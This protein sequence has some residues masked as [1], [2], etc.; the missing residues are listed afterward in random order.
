[1]LQLPARLP[2]GTGH[3][4]CYGGASAKPREPQAH[5]LGQQ[6]WGQPVWNLQVSIGRRSQLA[7]VYCCC[8]PPQTP[9]CVPTLHNLP[10]TPHTAALARRLAKSAT[11]STL[12]PSTPLHSSRPHRMPRP[13]RRQ[14]MSSTASPAWRWRRESKDG[15]AS[16]ATT[17]V[18]VMTAAGTMAAGTLAAGPKSRLLEVMPSA[19][20][21]AT[22]SAAT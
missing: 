14:A 16:S 10:P 12:L 17:T 13:C 19:S 15:A 8:M 7:T 2:V 4:G 6:P 22:S 5:V 18:V 11:M 21:E 1:M 9:S 20:R 3:H